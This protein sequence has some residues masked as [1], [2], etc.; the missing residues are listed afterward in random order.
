[1]SAELEILGITKVDDAEWDQPRDEVVDVSAYTEAAIV[2]TIFDG[3]VAGGSTTDVFL[4]TAV[5][6]A[7]ESWVGLTTL[8]SLT[9]NPTAPETH[10][11]YLQGPGGTGG[12]PGFARYLRVAVD[13]NAASDLTFDVRAI[14]K[15]KGGGGGASMTR[16][17]MLPTG[18]M[19]KLQR[20]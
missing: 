6:N 14:M 13:Q 2:V 20:G 16:S 3:T 9:A 1:M 4:D 12:Y 5:D 11:A 17:T 19:N 8:F 10:Y 7:E 18:I 15:R